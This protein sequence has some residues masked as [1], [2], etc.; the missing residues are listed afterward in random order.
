MEINKKY[1][2]TKISEY[3]DG[4]ELKIQNEAFYIINNGYCMSFIINI[5]NK[6]NYRSL[7]IDSLDKCGLCGTELLKNLD[8]FINSLNYDGYN[9]KY[10]Y[11]NDASQ[12]TWKSENYSINIFLYTLK[13]LTKGESWYNSLGYYQENYSEEKEEWLLIRN[14]TFEEIK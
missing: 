8:K 6:S 4:S 13:I 12:I 2:K 14:K 7:W 10:S 5:N 9:I 11:L 1:L 3:F